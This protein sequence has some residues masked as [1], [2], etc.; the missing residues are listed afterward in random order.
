MSR[1]RLY[2]QLGRVS[3]LP[4]VW[5]NVAAGIVLAGAR[6]GALVYAY[7]AAA[8]SCF[9]V[10]GMFLNDAFDRAIDA[11]ERPERPIPSGAVSAAEVFTVGFGLLAA[12][13]LL[14]AARAPG[15]AAVVAALALAGMIVLYDLWHKQNP[16]SPILMGACRWLVYATA[17]LAVAG[18][19]AV[20]VVAGAT[21]LFAYLIGLTYAAKQEQLAR[22]ESLWPLA[23][24]AAPLL[25]GWRALDRGIVAA[26]VWVLLLAAVLA[27]VRLLRGTAPDRFPRAVAGMI[28]GIAL[29]DALAIANAGAATTAAACALGWPATLAL[30]R[31]VRGT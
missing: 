20:P 12:G 10:G 13:M 2:L 26:A 31:W 8:L 9:Y 11:R 27:A 5:T 23:F 7:T 6:P 21:I 25:L 24:L 30:Q 3:N 22:V 16:L 18:S 28:A 1:R 15:A 14:I 4:T 17:A 29:V 19:L